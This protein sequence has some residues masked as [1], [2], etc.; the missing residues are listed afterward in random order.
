MKSFSLI[1]TATLTLA[2]PVVLAEEFK[3]HDTNRDG[4]MSEEEFYGAVESAGIYNQW[5]TN[6][7]GLIDASEYDDIGVGDDFNEWDYDE[8]DYLDAEE[9]YSG[10]FDQFD[11]DR[12]GIWGENEWDQAGDSG[13]LDV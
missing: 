11:S 5:D 4:S 13:W 7:D 9:F 1:V 6:S 3:D 2:S 8:N 12:D 10:T